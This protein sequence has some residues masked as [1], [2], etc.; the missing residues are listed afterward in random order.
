MQKD[1]PNSRN[2]Y[3]PFFLKGAARRFGFY[4]INYINEIDYL[5]PEQ[6]KQ[7]L[8]HLYISSQMT[9]EGFLLHA[10]VQL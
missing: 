9:L 2:S 8:H 10:S 6:G 3:P 1:V 7:S 4:K 5:G